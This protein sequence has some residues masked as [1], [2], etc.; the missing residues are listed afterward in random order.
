MLFSLLFS[1]PIAILNNSL[2]SSPSMLLCTRSPSVPEHRKVKVH[3]RPNRHSAAHPTIFQTWK[4]LF[5]LRNMSISFLH[6]RSI[7]GKFYIFE[8][9]N[10]FIAFIRPIAP[11]E[12]KS[13]VPTPVFQIFSLY[14]RQASGSS[15][16][17]SALHPCRRF[18]VSI[19]K[20]SSSPERG[21][22][23]SLHSYVEYWKP[24]VY[25]Q[26]PEQFYIEKHCCQFSQ[27]QIPLEHLHY[28]FIKLP[29]PDSVVPYNH[30]FSTVF[31][32]IFPQ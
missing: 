11:I 9:L 4:R 13:S 19:K 27:S 23:A 10:V 24:V 20:S 22:S 7:C 21:R 8:G 30:H 5:L 15:Q 29:T 28:Q 16:S 3:F 25:S 31:Y 2:S 1:F 14:I 32:Y 18:Q 26:F 17:V 12:I 6:T